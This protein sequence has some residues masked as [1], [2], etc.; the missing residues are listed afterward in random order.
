MLEKA[1]KRR[2]YLIF[3][4]C[5]WGNRGESIERLA[6]RCLRMMRAVTAL[7]P[8]F[9]RW[10]TVSPSRNFKEY[11]LNQEFLLGLFDKGTRRSDVTG[12]PLPWGGHVVWL[13]NYPR[14]EYPASVR[15]SA[16]VHS[17]SERMANSIHINL[18]WKVPFDAPPTVPLPP[19]VIVGL[20]RA[21]VEAWEPDVGRVMD[22]NL[23]DA[24]RANK[25]NGY[26]PAAGWS[27]YVPAAR[28]AFVKA[29]AGVSVHAVPGMGAI[30]SAADDFYTVTD[31]DKLTRVFAIEEVLRHRTGDMG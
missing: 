13:D 24:L 7:D 5:H 20:L 15:V 8:V 25:E 1:P 26:Y 16:G 14:D 3:L 31:Q 12:E 21:V 29:P 6:E 2:D 23:L 4:H 18:A 27:C 28:L 22:Q 30:W 17:A 9:Y 11:S 10:G 19:D